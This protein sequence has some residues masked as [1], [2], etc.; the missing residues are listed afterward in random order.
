M[1]SM[2]WVAAILA[3]GTL[4]TALY[5]GADVAVLIRGPA[6][7]PPVILRLAQAGEKNIGKG[8]LADILFAAFAGL[9]FQ[10]VVVAWLVLDFNVL[11]PLAR[12]LLFTEP[13][14]ASILA[15]GMYV[16]VRRHGDLSD[17]R[18]NTP[19]DDH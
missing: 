16:Y 1:T 19:S 3:V 8:S 2:T 14:A 13:V 4:L 17:G 12:L 9:F 5:F 6:S 10:A 11:D 18:L 15:T 7:V